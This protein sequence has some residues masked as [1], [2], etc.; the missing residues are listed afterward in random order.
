MQDTADIIRQLKQIHDQMISTATQEADDWLEAAIEPLKAKT[1]ARSPDRQE[2][3]IPSVEINADDSLINKVRSAISQI[4]DRKFSTGDIR[5]R[6]SPFYP[7][8]TAAKR[9]TLSNTLRKLERHY[10]EI[11]IVLRGT[12]SSPS[13]YRRIV[14][15]GA[16]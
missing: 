1:L 6:V 2:H 3:E 4:G 9:S 11:E 14:K 10:G 7:Q 12:G 15:E 5:E 16:S 13:I 8:D